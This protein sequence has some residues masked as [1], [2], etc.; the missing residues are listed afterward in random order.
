MTISTNPDDLNKMK[1]LA[2]RNIANGDW[3]DETIFPGETVAITQEEREAKSKVAHILT[4]VGMRKL[5]K[6]K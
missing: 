4:K 1:A 5:P 3:G 6:N 2:E